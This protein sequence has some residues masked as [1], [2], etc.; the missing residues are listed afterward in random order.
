MDFYGDD[1]VQHPPAMLVSH[2]D[3]HLSGIALGQPVP[4]N[5]GLGSLAFGSI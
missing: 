1:H 2:L 3:R 5:L 4:A